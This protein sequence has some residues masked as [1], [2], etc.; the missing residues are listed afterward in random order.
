MH[1]EK[2]EDRSDRVIKDNP[3]V[4]YPIN[5]PRMPTLMEMENHGH[6]D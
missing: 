1:R 4:S 2:M 6:P 5:A 3:E